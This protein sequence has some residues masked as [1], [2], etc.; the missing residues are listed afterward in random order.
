MDRIVLAI[1]DV[2]EGG[3]PMSPAIARL[4]IGDITKKMSKKRWVIIISLQGKL[5][6]CPRFPRGTVIK[7]SRCPLDYKMSGKGKFIYEMMLQNNHC[8]LVGEPF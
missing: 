1:K 3:A 8:A 4:I 2:M 7:W 6:S 5:T